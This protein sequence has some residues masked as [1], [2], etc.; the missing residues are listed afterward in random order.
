MS[1]VTIIIGL[2]I[3]LALPYFLN[4]VVKSKSQRKGVQLVCKIVGIAIV[5]IAIV[6][7]IISLAS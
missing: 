3:W 5:V 6:N 1:I 7:Y 4:D 2:L